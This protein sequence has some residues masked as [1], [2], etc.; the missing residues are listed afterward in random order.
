M[1]PTDI[2]FL[3]QLPQPQFKTSIHNI[4]CRVLTYPL[5]P[6]EYVAKFA[7]IQE[8]GNICAWYEYSLVIN[9]SLQPRPR[10]LLHQILMLM[11]TCICAE[12]TYLFC[13]LKDLVY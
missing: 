5:R 2:S 4:K 7:H 6:M 1:S 3:R 9:A 13:T 11:H 12:G 10:N 8:S